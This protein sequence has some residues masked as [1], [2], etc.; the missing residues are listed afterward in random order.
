[1]HPVLYKTICV[2]VIVGLAAEVHAEPLPPDLVEPESNWA[3]KS[4]PFVLN[5]GPVVSFDGDVSGFVSLGVGS[6]TFPSSYWLIF[7]QGI[8]A[9]IDLGWQ[10]GAQNLATIRTYVDLGVGPFL[11][12][13]GIGAAANDDGISFVVTPEISTPI[14]FRIGTGDVTIDPIVRLLL[15]AGKPDS[16][17]AGT[18]LGLRI[19]FP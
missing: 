5:T 6:I 7:T 10:F 13:G 8:A 19:A 1:M 2:F 17:R 11:I 18:F 9:G 4:S 12:G 15:Y 14:R 3:R 16:H